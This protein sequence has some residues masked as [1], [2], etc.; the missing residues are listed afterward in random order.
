MACMI[1]AICRYANTY[2][3]LIVVERLAVQL[4]L[5][6]ASRR[7]LYLQVVDQIKERIRSGSLPA[8]TRLP[9]VRQV[10]HDL[11]LTRLTVHNAYAELQADG[12]IESFV[13]RG[14]FVAARPA[15]TIDHGDPLLT[16]PTSV[17][18]PGE[19]ADLLQLS[20]Q[21]E[22]I[23]FAQASPA[24]ET[25]PL[26]EFGRAVQQAITTHDGAAL[27]G[28]GTSQGDP[29]LRDQLAV[30]LLERAV[31]ARPEQIVVVGGAQQG[32]DLVL[33]ALVQ[34][35]ETVLVEHPTYLGIIERS[36]MQ[37]VAL[38]GVPMDAEGI[39]LDALERAILLH[40]P[41][42]LYMVPTYHNPTGS[43]MSPDRQEALLALAARHGLLIL[44]DDIY[45][46]LPLDGQAPLP[47]KARD[48]AGSVIY[49]SSF[50]KVL[51]PGLRIGM[52]VPPPHLLDALIAAKRLADL[53]SP[54]LTQRAL[55]LYLRDVHWGAHLRTVRALYRERRD[56]MLTHLRRNFPGEV[57]WTRP[58]GGLSLWVELP[59]GVRAMDLYLDA[60]E[61]G[62]AFAPGEA[63]FAE[64]PATSYFRLSYGPQPADLIVK[65]IGI[66]S[67]LV[68][69]HVTRSRR[70]RPA[71]V[72]AVVPMV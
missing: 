21:P 32:I 53:Q 31:Q 51:M 16:A 2:N 55:A 25:F 46:A 20:Q 7:P 68:H 36:E 18:R 59:P 64:P 38:H 71:A 37:A 47:L 57:R 13:G 48:R 61:R 26:R 5:D 15:S 65:G 23:S 30:Y 41:R 29:L 43:T 14:S 62:V 10:A 4:E 39:R 50:S 24:A 67:E 17:R 12:W 72:H 42:L 52:L 8:G 44:E 11:G 40:R 60:I 9:P 1:V 28:Y 66:L 19:L 58:A 70:V 63:F 56:V 6:R 22:I 33:R 34:P 45:G 27:Y 54:Q 49:L 3:G 35:G 69:E